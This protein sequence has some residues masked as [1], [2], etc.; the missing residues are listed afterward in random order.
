[1]L[2]TETVLCDDA[3]VCESG[4][5]VLPTSTQDLRAEAWSE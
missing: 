2:C 3:C 1:M 5:V 4:G